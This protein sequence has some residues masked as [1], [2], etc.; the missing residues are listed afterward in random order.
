MGQLAPSPKE[1]PPMP[2]SA[3]TNCLGSSTEQSAP[4]GASR[5]RPKRGSFISQRKL[6]RRCLVPAAVITAALVT[7][8]ASPAAAIR[9]GDDAKI[10]DF[11][12]MASIHRFDPA[13]QSFRYACS[14][15]LIHARGLLAGRHCVE[16][17]EPYELMVTIG[18]EKIDKDGWP[19][20]D[21]KIIERV[22]IP[23]YA[24]RDPS[25]SDQTLEPSQGPFDIAIIILV[26][27]VRDISPVALARGPTCHE[28]GT[29]MLALGWGST[30]KD[31]KARTPTDTLQRIPLYL[32]PHDEC[33][34]RW[35]WAMADYADAALSSSPNASP[36]DYMLCAQAK[37]RGRWI[38]KSI[39]GTRPGDS[40]G[41]L[42]MRDSGR[43][44]QH[45]VISH[46]PKADTAIV[47]G[48][49][50]A[51]DLSYSGSVYVAMHR[52]WI[53]SVLDE[54]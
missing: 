8:P 51:E 53:D 23:A 26:R 37:Q 4:R 40:G 52:E 16:G 48:S 20:M 18:A 44:V 14:A 15:T 39:G 36:T 33:W 47:A 17:Y 28:A 50:D 24:H 54:L 35:P 13:T 6:K 46:L 21:L 27:A 31:S 10:A 1:S 32:R 7:L 42:L 9:A 3:F 49:A 30:A 11:P 2:P 41:P 12:F 34:T 5:H 45:G 29:E 38:F 22:E 19:I 43:W 25:A